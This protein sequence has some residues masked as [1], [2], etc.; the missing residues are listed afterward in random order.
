LK[1]IFPNTFYRHRSRG[2]YINPN[3]PIDGPLFF[4]AGPILGGDN[5][6]IQACHLFEQRIRGQFVVA[7]PN[8]FAPQEPLYYRGVQGPDDVFE[9]QFQWEQYYLDLASR[10]GCIIFWLPV[11]SRTNPRN[12]G[13]PYAMITR[14]ELGAWRTKVQNNPLLRMVI[15]AEDQF[16]GLAEIKRY[17]DLAFGK[18]IMPVYS[19]LEETINEAVV[20]LYTT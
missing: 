1:I 17:N 8:R 2:Y 5:W 10:S 19:S 12:D 14:D 15:G 9:D 4:L 6:H 16:P 20:L 18:G 7:T 11:E 3:I 13:N